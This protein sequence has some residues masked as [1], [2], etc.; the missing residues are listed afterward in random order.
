MGCGTTNT[1]YIIGAVCATNGNIMNMYCSNFNM[2]VP[3]LFSGSS[4]C[5]NGWMTARCNNIGGTSHAL[6]GTWY[7][8]Y[9]FAF[10][11][12]IMTWFADEGTCTNGTGCF[13]IQW[14]RP[15][16]SIN[17]H[18]S[19]VSIILNSSPGFCSWQWYES[20][21]NTGIAPWEICDTAT[22]F[23][24]AISQV[25]N[26]TG[27][28]VCISPNT[29]CF[30]LGGVPNTA[31]CSSSLIGS[32]WVEGNNLAYINANRW[33]HKIVGTCQ[34]SG[35]SSGAIWIDNSHYLHWANSGGCHFIAPWRICQF[36]S[37][38]TNGAPSNP[39]PGVGCAGALWV[40]NEFGLTHLS[41]I[42]SD[43]NKYLAG[44]GNY[45]YTF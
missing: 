25:T 39:S 15:S 42:G 43:G 37:S 27:D 28:S 33:K 32:I 8:G 29:V 40:D 6:T 12:A 1:L 45:P 26:K 5:A 14:Y 4:D 11:D 24:C 10:A 21:V 20:I 23:H 22:C 2:P 3:N 17:S 13:C 36:A 30:E 9:E 31:Q 38:F 35:A 34:G 41:Y 7:P 16:G 44:A 18:A 19:N